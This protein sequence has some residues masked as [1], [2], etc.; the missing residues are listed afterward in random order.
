M[1]LIT[2]EAPEE[3]SHVTETKEKKKKN[4]PGKNMTFLGETRSSSVEE[5]SAF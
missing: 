2:D 5:I 4:K 3:K 1:V